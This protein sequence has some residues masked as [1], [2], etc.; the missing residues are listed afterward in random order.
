[1]LENGLINV[2]PVFPE[3]ED[4]EDDYELFPN[5]EEVIFNLTIKLPRFTKIVVFNLNTIFQT[6]DFLCSSLT[7]STNY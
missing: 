7:F 2:G 5:P 1:M 3:D 6:V 4:L